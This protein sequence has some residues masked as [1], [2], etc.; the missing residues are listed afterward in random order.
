MELRRKL[1][2]VNR[3]PTQLEMIAGIAVAALLIAALALVMST[4]SNR[5]AH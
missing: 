5:H 3:I 1:E 2:A 4:R